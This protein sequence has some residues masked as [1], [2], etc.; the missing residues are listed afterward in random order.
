MEK[1]FAVFHPHGKIYIPSFLR[2]V[3]WPL[4]HPSL[5]RSGPA[6]ACEKMEVSSTSIFTSSISN[7]SSSTDPSPPA[8]PSVKPQENGY[9]SGDDA[10]TRWRNWFSLLL[11]RM[12]E[13]GK[14]QYRHDRDVRFEAKDC[15]RCEKWRDFCLNYSKQDINVDW[16]RLSSANSLPRPNCALHG[17]APPKDRRRIESRQRPMSA[18]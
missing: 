12:T 18:L 6:R 2:R 5:G 8:L 13:E 1:N 11:G 10:N 3:G 7:M 4:A 9:E 17:R 14:K 15:A 16:R